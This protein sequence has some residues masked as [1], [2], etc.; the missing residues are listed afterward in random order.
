MI[1][2]LGTIL[3]ATVLAPAVQPTSTVLSSGN[4]HVLLLPETVY[5][6]A[7]DLPTVINQLP[8]YTRTAETWTLSSDVTHLGKQTPFIGRPPR[9]VSLGTTR[10][11]QYAAR[12]PLA[13]TIRPQTMTHLGD[14]W[15]SS[16]L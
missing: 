10:L 11:V 9:L 3:D 8:M 12:P 1:F 13:D 6:L 2:P 7:V 16:L 5:L 14:R 4:L 15:P